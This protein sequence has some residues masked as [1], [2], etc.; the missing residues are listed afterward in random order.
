MLSRAAPMFTS[1]FFGPWRLPLLY[2][3]LS[4]VNK[5]FVKFYAA[6]LSVLL[7]FPKGK[8]LA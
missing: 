6:F 8:A 5:K 7:Y 2:G 1:S 4:Y 3:A